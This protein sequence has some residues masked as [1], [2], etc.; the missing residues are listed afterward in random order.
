MK[1]VESAKKLAKK[2]KAPLNFVKKQIKRGK[3]VE[4]EHTTNPKKAEKVAK[5]HVYERP[6]YYSQLEKMEKKPVVIDGKADWK[7]YGR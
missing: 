5:Q 4:K 1:P 7:K 3:Q 6:D 2:G